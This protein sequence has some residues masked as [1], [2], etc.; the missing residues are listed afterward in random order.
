MAWSEQGWMQRLR[1]QAEALS[2]SADR[3]DAASLTAADPFEAHVLRRAAF[4]LADRAESIPY[5]GMG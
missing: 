1:R 2:R 3:L 4:A 5:A